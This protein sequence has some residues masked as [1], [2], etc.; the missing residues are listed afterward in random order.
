MET[1]VST[2]EVFASSVHH[3]WSI[4]DRLLIT[5]HLLEGAHSE[6]SEKTNVV[7]IKTMVIGFRGKGT[8]GCNGRNPP[9]HQR[10]PPPS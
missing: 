9:T 4:C 1:E 5:R 6:Q 2:G 7:E 3:S 10:S 8:V